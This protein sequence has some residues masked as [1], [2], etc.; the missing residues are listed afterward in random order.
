MAIDAFFSMV[1]GCFVIKIAGYSRTREEGRSLYSPPFSVGGYSWLPSHARD[2]PVIAWSGLVRSSYCSDL[3]TVDEL[4][5]RRPELLGDDDRLTVRCDIVFMDVLGGAAAAAAEAA[6]RPLPP[7]DLHQHLGKLLSE[8]EGANVTFQM[9]AGGETF[10]AHRCVLAARSPVFRAQL[11]GPM[12]E[13][14]TASGVIAIDDMEAEVFSSL[15]TSST[16]TH[17]PLMPPPTA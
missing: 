16:P 9:V 8:K 7:S 15:L 12:K 6:A 10:A 11:F 2:S 13:G 5:R 3:V 1:S 14:S 17:C 4:E